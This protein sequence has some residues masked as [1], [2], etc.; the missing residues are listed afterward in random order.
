MADPVTLSAASAG[1][2]EV[3]GGGYGAAA[4]SG[5]ISAGGSLIGG[6]IS[7]MLN[8]QNT[9]WAQA[10]QR[11]DMQNAI[12]WRVQDAKSSGIHPLFALGMQ[13]PMSSPMVIGDQLGPA[14]AEAGQN[15][16]RS[17]ANIMTPVDKM[18][19]WMEMQQAKA[20][21]LESDARRK[22]IE[23]QTDA[24]MNPPGSPPG[25]G[26]QPEI[27]PM[28]QLPNVPGHPT[29]MIDVKPAEVT[30]HR[31]GSPHVTAGTR[32]AFEVRELGAGFPIVLPVAEGES[33]E[34][35]ISEMSYA[36]WAGLLQ[37]NAR[38][39]GE[40]WMKDLI[41]SRY[42]GQKPSRRYDSSKSL[43]DF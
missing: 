24:L 11:E 3:A 38:F 19:M 10:K 22:F 14:I 17:A 23:A 13:P 30:S 16:A 40:G 8:K 33:P 28:G 32:P 26:V 9:K 5:G 42:F 1:G 29:G 35:I 31:H 12:F 39:W 25:L 4:A 2:A 34:E 15:I 37:R 41:D 6:V 27:G 20:A 18:R 7:N 36:A 21:L 43:H